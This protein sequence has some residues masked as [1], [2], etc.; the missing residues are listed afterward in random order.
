MF[1]KR[2]IRNTRCCLIYLQKM[3]GVANGKCLEAIESV[4]SVPSCPMSKEEWE[5]ASKNKNCQATEQTCTEA[6]KF[7]YHCV[8]N[9]F[10]NE[11][12]EVCAPQKFIHGNIHCILNYILLK[13]LNP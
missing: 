6:E 7:V 9:G 12:I 1:V 5:S 13:M 8:I 3:C 2:K 11:T 4:V 10:V